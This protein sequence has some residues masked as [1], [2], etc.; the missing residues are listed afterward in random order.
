MSVFL[1][2]AGPDKGNNQ[3]FTEADNNSAVL[4]ERVPGGDYP[5]LAANVA[6]AA[7]VSDCKCARI[8]YNGQIGYCYY[9]G[10]LAGRACMVD[11]EQIAKEYG[12]PI[13]AGVD[14]EQW[15]S[16]IDYDAMYKEAEEQTEGRKLAEKA[17]AAAQE[18][19]GQIKKAVEK[20]SA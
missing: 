11:A 18:T 10:V 9:D 8:V 3:I 7:P 1:R 13:V 5:V 2:L 6:G 16:R 4:A 15:V 19:I 20:W 17:L 12:T 14:M